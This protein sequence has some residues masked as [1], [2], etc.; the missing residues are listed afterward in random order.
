MSRE[1]PGRTIII[2]VPNVAAAAGVDHYAMEGVANCVQHYQRKGYN[3]LCVVPNRYLQSDRLKHKKVRQN[4]T[5]EITGREILFELRKCNLLAVVPS[6]VY[7]DTFSIQTLIH[8]DGCIVSNDLYRDTT[9]V[10]H[11]WLQARRIAFMF[12]P[13]SLEYYL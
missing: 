6:G 7:D 8:T 10:P 1:D 3:I 13:G 11:D 4:F 5:Y 2:D 9:I 12:L